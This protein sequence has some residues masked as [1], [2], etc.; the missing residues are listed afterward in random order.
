[1]RLA[2]ASIGCLLGAVLLLVARGADNWSRA[3]AVGWYGLFGAAVALALAALVAAALSRGPG[4]KRRLTIIGLSL[5]ALLAVP[6]LLWAIV[7]L[8]P[9]AD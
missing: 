2:T 7:T 9:L 6:V 3:F 5:P 4:L 8:A 1:M